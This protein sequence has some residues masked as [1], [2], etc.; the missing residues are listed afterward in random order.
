MGCVVRR[1]SAGIGF[2]LEISLV[3]LLFP[4]GRLPS[5]R[6]RLPATLSVSGLAAFTISMTLT[7]TA[8]DLRLPAV[9]NPLRINISPGFSGFL[10]LIGLL[11][12]IVSMAIGVAAIIYR[13]RRAKGDE[14][15]QLKWFAYAAVLGMIII[16][17]IVIAS[18]GPWNTNYAVSTFLFSIVNAGIPIATGVAILKYHLYDIDVIIRR[19]LV[20]GALT[21]TLAVL[22][23]GSVFLLQQLIEKISGTQSSPVA[24]VISTLAIAALFT[25]LRSRIQRDIDR[26]F[27]RNKY[28]A[29]KTL[30]S[31]AASVRDEVELEQISAQLLATLEETLQPEYVT[32]WLK[33][34]SSQRAEQTKPQ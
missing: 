19:T 9:P 31:F 17:G 26:R 1:F 5:P 6:W 2:F 30:E 11:G 25:P 28:D 18:I 32:L 33:P 7:T 3:L 24:I 34:A 27:Y 22:F 4:D 16:G 23:F 10:D 8:T 14:R 15:Q 21:A 13:F 29:Q 12:V 20:Y